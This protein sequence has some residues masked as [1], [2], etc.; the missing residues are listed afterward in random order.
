MELEAKERELLKSNAG[1]GSS[2]NRQERKELQKANNAMKTAIHQKLVMREKERYELQQKGDKAKQTMDEMA[3][4]LKIYNSIL[5][6]RKRTLVV[7]YLMKNQEDLEK[8]LETL[9]EH[10]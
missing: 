10:F 4:N 7:S 5:A 2:D 9:Y 3:D 8:I 6:E 1:A